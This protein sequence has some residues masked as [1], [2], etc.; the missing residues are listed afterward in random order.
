MIKNKILELRSWFRINGKMDFEQSG[1]KEDNGKF[2]TYKCA[3]IEAV[4]TS[5]LANDNEYD[6]KRK[7]LVTFLRKQNKLRYIQIYE[8]DFD[9]ADKLLKEIYKGS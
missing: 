5:A 8:N 6:D 1:K 7:Q 2:I 4:F 9:F 3:D